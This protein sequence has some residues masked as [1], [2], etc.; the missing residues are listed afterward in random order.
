MPNHLD[1]ADASLRFRQRLA[2]EDRARGGLSIEHVG[3][4]VPATGASVGAVDFQDMM[5]CLAQGTGK[6]S[7]IRPGSFDTEGRHGAEGAGPRVEEWYP[8]RLTGTIVA[9]RRTPNA[10]RATAAWVSL[11]VSIPMMILRLGASCCLAAIRASCGGCWDP[12]LARADRTVTGS[13]LQA[14]IRSRTRRSAGAAREVER[15]MPGH[16]VNRK[17][18]SDPSGSS[19]ILTVV[20]VADAAPGGVGQAKSE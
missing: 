16:E 18:G 8:T 20:A 4:A 9:P 17:L 14:P 13:R 15:S 1:R 11:C 7:P 19:G 3:L 5:P 10:F 12:A 2:G 6:T